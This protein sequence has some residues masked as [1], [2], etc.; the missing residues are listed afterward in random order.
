MGE[1]DDY[2]I[3]EARKLALRRAF[4]TLTEEA[5]VS[6]DE[7]V[8][9][10]VVGVRV[11]GYSGLGLSLAKQPWIERL[12]LNRDVHEFYSTSEASKAARLAF[13]SYMHEVHCEFPDWGF[14]RHHG[15]PTA[16]H[17]NLILKRKK[18]TPY[19]RLTFQPL[20]RF[21]KCVDGKP[22]RTNVRFTR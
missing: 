5:R 6:E 18:G 14:D 22:Y 16:Q 13:E 7:N 3:L 1:V 15:L 10:Q 11:G 19:H 9:K 2:R 20:S 12:N 21:C 8:Y 17:R 4:I